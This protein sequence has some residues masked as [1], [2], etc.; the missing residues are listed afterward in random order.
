MLA[1]DPRAGRT[2][3]NGETQQYERP[4]FD[5]SDVGDGDEERR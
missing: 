3:V 4:N 5:G 2:K 1:R